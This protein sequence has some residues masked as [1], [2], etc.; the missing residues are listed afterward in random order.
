MEGT[1][2]FTHGA[3]GSCGGLILLPSLEGHS[4]LS[5]HDGHR[6]V[7][8]SGKTQPINYN[9]GQRG[10]S[11][12]WKQ[13]RNYQS[14]GGRDGDICLWESLTLSTSISAWRFPFSLFHRPLLPLTHSEPDIGKSPLSSI[15]SLT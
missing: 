2:L 12:A 11:L 5:S 8:K 7:L 10:Q 4:P 1:C 13:A 9:R 14:A 15:F 3:A 6:L